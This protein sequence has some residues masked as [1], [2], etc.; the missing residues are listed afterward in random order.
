MVS[1]NWILFDNK[2]YYFDQSGTMRTGWIQWNNLWYYL[3]LDGSMA[4]GVNT[5]DG[6]QVDENGVWVL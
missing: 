6:Y 4:S 5:P 3:N 1:N 2:W